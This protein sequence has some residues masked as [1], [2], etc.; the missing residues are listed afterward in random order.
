MFILCPKPFEDDLRLRVIG[1]NE[2]PKLGVPL[3]RLCS[4]LLLFAVLKAALDAVKVVKPFHALDGIVYL[5]E[6]MALCFSNGESLEAV[7]S[8]SMKS[9]KGELVAFVFPCFVVDRGMG[10]VVR[11]D[12]RVD[13]P[14]GGLSGGGM[15]GSRGGA[16]SG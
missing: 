4:L 5:I 6:K 16:L 15:L 13:S 8:L 7:K 12:F 10:G 2:L 11:W 14:F 3:C 9:M 1:I